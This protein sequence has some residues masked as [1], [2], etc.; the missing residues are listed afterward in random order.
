MEE[1]KYKCTK[2]ELQQKLENLKKAIE[3]LDSNMT[4]YSKAFLLCKIH[5][6]SVLFRRAYHNILKD[7]RFDPMFKKYIGRVYDIV[8][9]LQDC[10]TKGI[11]DQISYVMKMENLYNVYDYAKF[12]IESYVN[13]DTSYNITLF[14]ETLD[15]NKD[16]FE[17]CI[18]VIEELDVDL[19]Q[20]YL[21]KKEENKIVRYNHAIKTLEDIAYGIEHGTLL[22][23]RKFN[24]ITF[25]KMTPFTNS[26]VVHDFVEYHEINPALGYKLGDYSSIIENFTKATNPKITDI[27]LKY[28][29][30]NHYE[31]FKPTTEVDLRR[32]Y[33]GASI[34]VNGTK[35]N[36]EEELEVII[37]YLRM[38]ELPFIIEVIK[39]VQ[40]K[41][42]NGEITH[43][44]VNYTYEEYQNSIATII[45]SKRTRKK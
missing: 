16:T 41:Y 28:I 8:A 34:I 24:K 2:E 43:E 44:Q 9:F 4:D 27:L 42:R 31:K 12:V 39:I 19:Y 21:N 26:D 11:I 22:D 3:I 20:T 13:S 38:N 37:K 23:G 15:I 35:I 7:G 30:E 32:M 18:K 45:P 25:L 33:R 29:H 14:L 1:R 5:N 36:M 17:F 40:E 10:E 6:G